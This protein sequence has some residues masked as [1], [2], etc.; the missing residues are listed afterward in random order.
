MGEEAIKIA[1][2]HDWL[3]TNAGAEKVLRA[4]LD[5]YP[6]SDIF[7]LVD[8][9]D[10]RQREEILQG[11]RTK[12]SFI[13]HL[14]FAK[15]HF[16][17]YLPLFPKAMERL[18]VSGYDLLISSSWAFAK[19][20]KKHPHQ[21]HICYCHTPIRYAWDLF[22]EYTSHLR[23]PKKQLVKWTLHK[24]RKWDL[25]TASHVDRFIANS[26]FVQKRI[27]RIYK[28]ESEVIYPPVDTDFFTFHG[29]KEDFYLSA[30]RLVPYK[31]MAMIVESFNKMPNKRLVVIGDG[32]EYGRLRKIAGKNVEILGFQSRDTLKWYMQRAKAF[33]YGALEDFG[34]VVVEA[35]SCGT[36][37]IAFGEGG[38]R[39]SVIDGVTGLF[40]A[41][42]QPDALVEAVRRFEKMEFD[43]EKVRE[44]AL[45]F[46]TKEFKKK[47]KKVIDETL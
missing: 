8:F 9:L 5:I 4:I 29:K 20:V 33:V 24:I 7:T 23:P 2:V 1:I 26:H 10:E 12:R 46:D 16:R 37:V 41:S 30:S 21:K 11:K 18:D 39:E 45:K 22:E 44:N 14:P 28:R 40:F 19:G 43:Y 31:K 47:L 13:Q 27:Q 17:N 15:K 42:Q 34:I 36:P 38:A 6:N 3:V 25:Q 32:E 35:Q